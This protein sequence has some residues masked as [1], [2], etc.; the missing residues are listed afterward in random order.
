[1]D[2]GNNLNW[3]LVLRQTYFSEPNPAYPK[4][5]I[6]IPPK[7]IQVDRYT[8]AIGTSST[9]AKSNWHVGAF[10][11]PRLPFSVSSTSAFVG[12]V[13]SDKSQAVFLNQLTLV[14][15][16]DFGFNP[17]ALEISI[18][19]WIRELSIE[20]WKYQGDDDARPLQE[21]VADIKTDLERIELK[22]DNHI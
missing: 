8:L 2:F 15:F 22:L 19:V 20:I 7:L 14:Q 11:V 10:V 4:G 16:K 12:L 13:R 6:P 18:P 1:M 17:Y 5:Y 21:L 3:D 9:K